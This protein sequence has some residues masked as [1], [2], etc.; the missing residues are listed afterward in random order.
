VVD[1]VFKT[2]TARRHK[3]YP[4]IIPFLEESYKTTTSLDRRKRIEKYMSF[5]QC[6][7]CRGARLNERALSVLIERRSIDDLVSL[8]VVELHDFLTGLRLE[9]ER[10]RLAR[11]LIREILE[12]LKPI[13]EVGLGYLTLKRS[14]PT[15]SAGELQRL[16]LAKH[17]GSGLGGLLYILDEPTIGLHESEKASLVKSLTRL[18][19]LGNSVLVVEH[20]ETVIRSA[21]YVIDLGP[22]AGHHGGSVV[23]VGTPAQIARSRGSITGQYLR[24][25]IT[26]KPERRDVRAR[27][28]IKILGAAENNL[29]SIDVTIPLGLFVCITGVSGSGK[30]S[31]I[32]ETLYPALERTLF[33]RRVKIGKHKSVVGAEH[34]DKVVGIDQSPIGRSPRSNPASYVGVWDMIRD[35]YARLPRAR[36]LGMAKGAFSFNTDEQQCKRCKGAG[37]IP[38]DMFFLGDVETVCPECNGNRYQEEVLSVTY[39]GKSIS[40]VLGLTFEQAGE[41]FSEQKEIVSI[42]KVVEELG[43]GYLKMGQPA[44]T[45]AGGEAQRLKLI[46]ELKKRETGRTLYI[47]DEPTTGLHFADVD[48]LLRILHRLVEVGNSVLVVEHNLSVIRTADYIIDLGPGGGRSGGEVVACGTPEIIAASQASLTGKFLRKGELH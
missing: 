18:R 5:S 12:R 29:K 42:I 21:D 40:D 32:Q 44:T 9:G 48:K 1:Y 23:A 6:P 39:R 36:D 11:E 19:D 38:V 22:G 25:P 2:S 35:F 30:S 8:P 4:G 43:L 27:H 41:F 17:L 20:D 28:S 45:L 46:Y 16:S 31:L 26:Y 37:V 24:A 14:S 47:L 33:G 34:I 3:Q 13:K 15:L 7:A 10:A